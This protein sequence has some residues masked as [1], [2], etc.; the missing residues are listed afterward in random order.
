MSLLPNRRTLPVGN[1]TK[2][3]PLLNGIFKNSKGTWV[4]WV[5]GKPMGSTSAPASGKNSPTKGK[6][7]GPGGYKFGASF[8]RDI[9]N[10]QN[11][12]R[13]V[14]ATLDSQGRD[15]ELEYMRTLR[16]TDQLFDKTN[17][18]NLAGA[19]ARGVAFSSPYAKATADTT[20]EF[21]KAFG[22]LSTKR[23]LFLTN[24][25][26]Q[27]N[28]IRTGFNDYLRGLALEQAQ[29]NAQFG[30]PKGIKATSP[31]LPKELFDQ[32]FKTEESNDFLTRL[33]NKYGI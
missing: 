23:K 1:A 30:A 33:R 4:K 16:D 32:S 7:K 19:A 3:K 22:D 10:R 9:L 5:N 17:Q 11:Q 27:R 13:G 26:T 25:L 31:K 28:L 21:N 24:D 18:A 15:N 12:D 2:P 20:N 6:V 8:Y 29:Q 14:L